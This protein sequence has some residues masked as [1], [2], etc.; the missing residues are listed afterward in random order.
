MGGFR[1]TRRAQN[2]TR[3]AE[4]STSEGEP[5]TQPISA[6]DTEYARRL[7]C[8]HVIDAKAKNPLFSLLCDFLGF[9]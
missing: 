1:R 6:K 5:R 4:A 2:R 7:R 3:R 8:A 9:L